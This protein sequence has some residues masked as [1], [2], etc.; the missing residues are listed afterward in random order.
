MNRR[1]YT[2]Y[3]RL[4]QKGKPPRPAMVAGHPAETVLDER[5]DP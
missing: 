1:L 2:V 5:N 3:R 4:G